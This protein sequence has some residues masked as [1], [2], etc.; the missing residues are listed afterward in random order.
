MSPGRVRGNTTRG[1]T[2]RA[3]RRVAAQAGIHVHVARD[4]G[5]GGMAKAAVARVAR[6]VLHA[7]RVAAFELSVTLVSDVRMRALNTRFLRRRYLTDVIAFPLNSV[8]GGRAGDVY[9]APG[10]AR[11]SAREHRVSVRD[12]MTRLVV[13]GVL[14]TLGYDHPGG[15]ARLDSAMWRRQERLV[16]RLARLGRS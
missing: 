2:P 6:A 14:H 7:E 16:A 9:V 11:L 1:G 3:A 4:G 10:A 15:A 12:E 8:G 5:R 13:H